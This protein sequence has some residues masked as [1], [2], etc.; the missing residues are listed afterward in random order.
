LSSWSAAKDLDFLMIRF[1]TSACPSAYQND[2][3]LV[4]LERS[5]G[6][7]FSDE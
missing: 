5:E 4:I 1:F 2:T 3:V 7:G 6:S